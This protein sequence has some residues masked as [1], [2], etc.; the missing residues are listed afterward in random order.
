MK[1]FFSK[2]WPIAVIVVSFFV[3]DHFDGD[4][5]GLLIFLGILMLAGFAVLID[6]ITKTQV[7]PRVRVSVKLHVNVRDDHLEFE[8]LNKII[9]FPILPRIGDLISDFG[10]DIGEVAGVN[11]IGVGDDQD[12]LPDASVWCKREVGNAEEMQEIVAEY[13]EDGWRRSH[14]L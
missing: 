10:V 8:Y 3:V 12:G 11:L 1:N 9:S 2:S 14:G 13:E 6:K 7:D 4:I 5:Q